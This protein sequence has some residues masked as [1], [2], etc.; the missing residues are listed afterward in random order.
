MNTLVNAIRA[1]I[2]SPEHRKFIKYALASV[3]SVIVTQIVLIFCYSGVKL[4]GGWS[5]FIASSVAAVP[6]YFLNRNW[7]W[8]KSG[9]SHMRKEVL[10]FWI[11]VFI[12]LGFSAL[13]GYYADSAGAKV[14]DSHFFRTLIITGSNVGGFALLW[15]LKFIIFNKILFAHRPADEIDPVL[16]GRS[17]IPT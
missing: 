14:T 11:M 15:V 4:S 9:K 17:G 8:R 2:E 13:I 1:R 6:S 10:P 12:G 7:V 3:I 5:A 16:D